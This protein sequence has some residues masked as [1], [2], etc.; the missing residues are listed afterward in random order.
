VH[1]SDIIE[2]PN[3]IKE[4]CFNL[5]KEP[6]ILNEFWKFDFKH[7]TPFFDLIRSE[8]LLGFPQE[9]GKF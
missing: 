7:Q 2:D 6:F 3:I 8:Y 5:I 1:S 9:I 4:I